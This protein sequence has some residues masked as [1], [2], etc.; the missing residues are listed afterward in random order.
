MLH[1]V[2]SKN[3]P[4]STTDVRRIV[5]NCKICAE[6]KPQFYRPQEG[7]LIKAMRPM[8]RLNL[9]FKGPLQSNCNNN[10]LLVVIDEY[11]RFPFVFPC[12][13]M[14]TSTVIKCLDRLFALCGTAGFVHSDN[15]PAFVSKEFKTYLFERGI[16]SSTSSVYH[17]S[18]NG[19]A[20]KTV[21]TVWKAI[22]LALKSLDL[23]PSHWEVV[24]EDVLHSMRSL[25]CTATNTTPHERFFSFSRRSCSGESLPSWLTQGRKAYLRRFVRTSKHDPLVDEVELVTVNPSYARV[26][27]PG[28]REVTVNLRDLAPRPQ[29]DSVPCPDRG[30]IG[31]ANTPARNEGDTGASPGESSHTDSPP[32][33]NPNVEST[34]DSPARD[35][36]LPASADISDDGGHVASRRS[37]RSNKG[38]P[39][40]RYGY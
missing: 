39:P 8:E 29:E 26:R 22:Q 5:S 27:F 37:A 28:G 34:P 25:L 6:V 19:Q 10:Y 23:P 11:S 36:S 12:R 35:T 21:G 17:P 33:I 18:G 3:L 24:L 9:D 1:F 13:D 32:Q 31:N 16:A 38:V 15:G 30:Q 4:Y 7:S 20:E 14:T 40:L 2:R